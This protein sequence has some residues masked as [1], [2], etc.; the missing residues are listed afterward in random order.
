MDLL[1][2]D[3]IAICSEIFGNIHL[4]KIFRGLRML[5]VHIHRLW[6][7]V[8]NS[9][10]LLDDKCVTSYALGNTCRPSTPFGMVILGTA[11]VYPDDIS[12]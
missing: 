8:V 7:I 10:N 11:R 4:E 5:T 6:I 1:S 12:L 2:R 9:R 3:K